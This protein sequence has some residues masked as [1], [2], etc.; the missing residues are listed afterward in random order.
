[1]VTTALSKSLALGG[2]RAGVARLPGGP[3]G[4]ALCGRVLEIASEIWSATAVPVQHAAALAFTEPPELAERVASS[5]SLHA[6]VC[7]AVAGRFAAAGLDVR[8]PQAAFYLYP[9]FGAWRGP[10]AAYHG[11][12]TGQALARRLLD[13][14]SRASC[15]PARSAKRAARCGCGSPPG[16]CTGTPTPSGNWPSP[17]PAR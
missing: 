5:R 14:Y 4:R 13:R 9:S 8:P 11:V 2:W 3:G 12:T 6:A 7:R 16:C 10:L 1:V 17:P 15:P